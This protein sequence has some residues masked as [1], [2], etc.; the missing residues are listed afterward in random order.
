MDNKDLDWIFILSYVYLFIYFWILLL[1]KDKS[2][3][4][5]LYV[6][7]PLEQFGIWFW[8]SVHCTLAYNP[9]TL[10]NVIVIVGLHVKF[11]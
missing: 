10:T 1:L 9:E 8:F 4:L 5:W 6:I 7:Q 3:D 11:K 2:C